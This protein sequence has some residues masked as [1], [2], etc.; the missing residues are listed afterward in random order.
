MTAF[1]TL[2]GTPLDCGIFSA[3]NLHTVPSSELFDRCQHDISR[4][5][6]AYYQYPVRHIHDAL[7][8]ITCPTLKDPLSTCNRPTAGRAL[9]KNE[10]EYAEAE[11]S[12]DAHTHRR[13]PGGTQ[14]DSD[15]DSRSGDRSH[16]N[17]E[18]DPVPP[19]RTAVIMLAEGL[20]DWVEP[21]AHDHGY[22]GHLHAVGDEQ[23]TTYEGTSGAIDDEQ[24]FSEDSRPHT[25]EHNLHANSRLHTW[26]RPAVLAGST[27]CGAV[28]DESQ[29]RGQLNTAAPGEEIDLETTHGHR[30]LQYKVSSCDRTRDL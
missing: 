5:Q 25:H 20:W 11:S 29:R 23:H 7:I 12:P 3:Q 8:T 21:W 18:P 4:L 30:S 24:Q 2:E 22:N 26:P 9:G 17:P 1:V 15:R 13:Q 19:E 16:P 6:E 14:R 27:G 28:G 10:G